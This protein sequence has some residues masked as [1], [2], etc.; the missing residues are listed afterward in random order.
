MG[1][2]NWFLRFE[3]AEQFGLDPQQVGAT[4]TVRTWQRWL[5][6][7]QAEYSR[8]A[9]ELAKRYKALTDAPKEVLDA[10]TWAIVQDHDI[11]QN[12]NGE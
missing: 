1:L 2:P 4:V 9:H 10:M 5:L 8:K 6:K 3:Y 12:D 7:R 11:E